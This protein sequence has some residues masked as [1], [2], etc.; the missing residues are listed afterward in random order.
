MQWAGVTELAEILACCRLGFHHRWL[1]PERQSDPMQKAWL[2]HD[3]PQCGY[4]QSWM[5]MAVA[6]R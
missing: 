4:Y 1:L 5:I 6:A 3:V 2:D